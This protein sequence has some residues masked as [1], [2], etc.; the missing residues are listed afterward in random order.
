MSSDPPAAAP[1]DV[2]ALRA[3][4]FPEV[5][6]SPFL[7]AASFTPLPWR[8][9]HAVEAHL[10]RRGSG[11]ALRND[12]FEPTLARA[13]AAAARLVGADAEEIALLP[14]TSFGVNL[15]AACLPREPGR[16]IVVSDREFPANVHPWLQLARREGTRVDLVPADAH[17][18][19]D[20]ARLLEEVARGD[21]AILAV[22]AV[23]FTDGFRAD[24]PALGEACRA[25]GTW[26]VV[27][28]IQALGQVPLDVRACGIDVLATGAQK[29]LCGPYGTGFAYV[30]RALVERME[31]RVVGWTADAGNADYARVTDYAYDLWG[32]ARRFEVATPAFH[33]VAG[34]TRSLELLLEV[35][36]ASISAHVLALTDRLIAGMDAAGIAVASDRRA[37]KRS[38][39]VAVVPADPARAYRALTQAGVAC[40]LREGAIRIAPHLYND[41]ADIDRAIEVLAGGGRAPT[42]AA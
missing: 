21:V 11:H 16:R 41:A 1:V 35:G 29:W 42:P 3:A 8:T 2:A 36:V 25:R 37:E 15:A 27:D 23:Q 5:G 13:R 4:E 14:N 10:R 30:R 26:L 7:N 28:A 6:A 34:M 38:G 24:L 39:I 20:E 17:G 19:P 40:S 12:D 9:I 31:P 22:S 33:D 32:D 18:H